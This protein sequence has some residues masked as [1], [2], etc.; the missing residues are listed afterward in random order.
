MANPQKIKYVEARASYS[1]RFKKLS[2][3]KN[4]SF[5]YQTFYLGAAANIW[6]RYLYIDLKLRLVAYLFISVHEKLASSKLT[7]LVTIAFRP[8]WAEAKPEQSPRFSTV[9]LV[10]FWTIILQTLLVRLL[11]FSRDSLR[12]WWQDLR[13]SSRSRSPPLTVQALMSR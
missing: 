6:R 2:V 10:A 11:T 1:S 9:R 13:I 7:Q 8:W 3:L 4:T 12:S 5:D